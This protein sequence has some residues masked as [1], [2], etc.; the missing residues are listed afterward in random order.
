MSEVMID[1]HQF[2]EMESSFSA[3]CEGDFMFTIGA[4]PHI[5]PFSSRVCCCCCVGSS[6]YSRL[7]VDGTIG[8]GAEELAS[9]SILHR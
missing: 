8:R 7:G 3:V 5:Q 6:E 9:G 2:C 4:Q 1:A